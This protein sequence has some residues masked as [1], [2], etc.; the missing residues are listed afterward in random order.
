[1]NYLLDT[2][3]FL[4][5]LSAPD[6][7]SR[8]AADLIRN[9]N[10]SVH[11]SAVTAFEIAIKQSLGK[12]KVRTHLYEELGA[13]GLVEL[14]FSYTHGEHIRKLPKHHSDPFDRMLIAQAIIEGFILVT[15]DR[16]FRDYPVK[17]V[18]T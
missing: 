18:W 16:K 1:M 14:P 5:M 7:L 4:W 13:R 6:R 11:V 2:H 12:L 8:E 17:I 15:H 9:P 10:N 3:V